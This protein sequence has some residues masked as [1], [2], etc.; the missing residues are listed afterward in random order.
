MDLKCKSYVEGY[1]REFQS[2]F[3]EGSEMEEEGWDGVLDV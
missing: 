2:V 3:S 1:V